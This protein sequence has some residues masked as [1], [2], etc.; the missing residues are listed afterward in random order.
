MEDDESLATFMA[1]VSVG[2]TLTGT[3]AEITPLGAAMLLDGFDGDP[4]GFI[5]CLS[6]G[7]EGLVHLS[8]LS[9]TPIETP[10]QAVQIGDEVM[11]TVIAIDLLRRRLALSCRR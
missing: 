10:D 2:D 8:E 7:I 9:T 6:D 4:V 3:V 5:G 1:T 11:V